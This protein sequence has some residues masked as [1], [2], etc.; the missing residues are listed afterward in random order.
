[1]SKI[2]E[3]DE[4]L[5]LMQKWIKWFYNRDMKNTSNWIRFIYNN[6]IKDEF[7]DFIKDYNEVIYAYKNDIEKKGQYHIECMAII[8]KIYMDVINNT[9]DFSKCLNIL[10]PLYKHYI[11]SYHN[12]ARLSEIHDFN[13]LN[14]SIKYYLYCFF[15]LISIEGVYTNWIKTL[16]G[17]YK[18]SK[19]EKITLNG[20]DNMKISKIREIMT[21]DKPY[22][23]ILF[24][25]YKDGNYRNA[26]AH[27]DFKLIDEETMEFKHFHKG[28]EK[29]HDV[30]NI[31]DFYDL[32]T[33]IF[34]V[35]EISS[36]FIYIASLRDICMKY[37]SQYKDK[38]ILP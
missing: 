9:K 12:V 7:S 11:D 18:T 30:I 37:F 28:V 23:D 34:T 32:F 36:E 26:I 4:S 15:Y 31:S 1:M 20:I 13:N 5:R 38:M 24:D 33:K 14:S 10:N 8:W 21:E 3:K 25:G 27:S 35:S 17:L 6:I 19:K 2:S 29:F 16:Y 22:Y